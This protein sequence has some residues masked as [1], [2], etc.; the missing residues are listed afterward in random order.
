MSWMA[1]AAPCCCRAGLQ[2]QQC[3]GT[4]AHPC[5]AS[6]LHQLPNP[7]LVLLLVG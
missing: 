4:V 6:L 3:S 7:L 5:A 2:A 1:P